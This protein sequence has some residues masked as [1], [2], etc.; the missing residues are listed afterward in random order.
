M[1]FLIDDHTLKKSKTENVNLDDSQKV[2]EI[3]E[4]KNQLNEDLKEAEE[5]EEIEI[6]NK[7]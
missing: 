7:L 3:M 4:L 1:T 6:V 5:R 2:Y